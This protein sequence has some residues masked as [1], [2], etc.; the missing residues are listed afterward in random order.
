MVRPSFLRPGG[1][2]GTRRHSNGMASVLAMLFLVLFATLAVGF[3]A[4]TSMSSQVARNEQY[5]ATARLSADAG[6]EF[7]RYQLGSMNLPIGT[8]SA[9]L[10]AN[11]AT[12]LGSALNGTTNMGSNTVAVTSGTIYIPSQTGYITVDPTSHAK[13]QATITQVAGTTTLVVTVHGFNSTAKCSRGIQLQFQQTGGPYSLVGLSSMTMGS[14]AFTDSYNSSKG[15][16]N[17]A[18][19]NK[20]GSIA[21]NGNIVLNNTAKVKGNAM[22]G[23]SGTITIA[24]SAGVTGVAAP[25]ITPATQPSVTMPTSYTDLGDVNMTSGTASLPGGTYLIHN[26]TLGGTANFTW[27]GPV[28]VYVEN[29]YNV[30]GSAVINT[31]QNIPA[32]RTLYFLPT[33]TSATWNGTNVCVGTLYA[34]DTNF[35]ISGSVEMFGRIVAKS[36]NNT[37]SGGMHNDEA[38]PAVGGSGPYAPVQGSYLE[39]Q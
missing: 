18:T 21:S 29:S 16:Y 11:T 28:T 4:T 10:L 31:Y 33:C 38:L 12:Q 35:T 5:L 9:T 2:V 15:A 7:M 30:T 37:S 19:A 6:M 20:N 8:T 17:A 34:P 25:L 22:Y 23:M 26:L 32:N 27:T 39:V 24:T 13:F 36:I 14:T 1:P 3:V